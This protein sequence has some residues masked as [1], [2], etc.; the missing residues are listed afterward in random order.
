MSRSLSLVV[1]LGATLV[2]AGLA[3][4]PPARTQSVPPAPLARFVGSYRNAIADGS[5]ASIR[6]AIE[7]VIAPMPEVRRR[8]AHRRLIASSPAIR[9]ITMTSDGEGWVVD[10]G[11]GRRN[12]T[13]RLGVF[14]ENP[15]AGG[16]TVDVKHELVGDSL[17]ET[18]RE[19]RGGA[20]HLFALSNG[21]RTL[22]L[23]ATIRSPHLPGPIRYEVTLERTR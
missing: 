7:T 8:I 11:R 20:V 22:T 3:W 23:E 14:A 15:A 19:R 5:A 13:P 16:G 10:Y 4:A 6:E 18:Y 12:A 9:G 17:R 1:G 2:V 21:G